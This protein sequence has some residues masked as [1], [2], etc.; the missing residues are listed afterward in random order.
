MKEKALRKANDLQ[1]KCTRAEKNLQEAKKRLA[2]AEKEL[3]DIQ[4]NPYFLS[5]D[6]I[7]EL[8]MEIE[9]LKVF[10]VE[11]R[12]VLSDRGGQHERSGFERRERS[13]DRRRH[14]IGGGSPV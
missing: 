2:V 11:V 14:E 8:T 7:D 1:K 12:K 9:E 13:S 6:A 3:F 5:L 4:S 10:S